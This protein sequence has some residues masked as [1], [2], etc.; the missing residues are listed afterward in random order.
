[1]K[2]YIYHITNKI[3]NKK[4][5]G[6]TTDIKHRLE[7]HF[8]DLKNNKHHSIKLQRAYNKYGKD[9]FEI[10]YKEV[11]VKDNDAL[12]I[13]E[14]QEIEKFNSYNNGYNMT[15]GGEGCSIVFSF[16]E[17]V[18][19]YQI[20][21]RYKGVSRYIA[22][23]YN[24][25]HTV[26]DNLS[27]NTLYE[28]IVYNEE[29]VQKLIQTLNL[30]KDNLNE[31]YLPHNEKK[32]NKEKCFEILSIVTNKTGYDKTLCE[33][34]NISSKLIWR[35]K[36]NLI[37]TDYIKEFF[38]LSSE[39]QLNLM[40]S[41]F[42]KYDIESKKAQR[43]RKGVKNALTQEQ[44]NYILDNKDSKKRVEIARDLG[45]SADRVGHVIL[46]KSYKDLVN[47]YYSSKLN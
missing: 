22:R 18:I 29:E 24:C 30:S 26:I 21:K 1:M 13:L 36:N 32:L 20:L 10:S 15:L 19:L 45:I 9:N 14:L 27:K 12:S 43:Q 40:N 3:N 38:E 42:E 35:L 4:Y 41:T 37:Y 11:E 25:D 47:N 2:G 23:F 7:S 33:I 6:K 39:Q 34:F 28:N 5:I 46:G 44:I 31:N 8:S 16:S 17:S